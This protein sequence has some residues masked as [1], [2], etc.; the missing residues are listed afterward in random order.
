MFLLNVK[1]SPTQPPRLTSGDATALLLVFNRVALASRAPA[2]FLLIFEAAKTL[3]Q[4]SREPPLVFERCRL[5]RS[6]P[7]HYGPHEQQSA[8]VLLPRYIN[9]LM[10]SE[11]MTGNSRQ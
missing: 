8:G 10:P 5:P 9:S 1:R 3:A 6:S 7:H 4:D 2:M 11:A